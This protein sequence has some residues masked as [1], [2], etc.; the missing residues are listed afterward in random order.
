[1]RPSPDRGPGGADARGDR[2]G[3]GRRDGELRRAE[4]AGQP[5]GAPPAR[6]WA[7]GPRCWSGSAPGGRRDW[8]SALLAV[9]KAGGAYVPLD[10]AFPAGPAGF[11]LEDA[12]VAGPPHRAGPAR[13]ACR[14]ADPRSL[15]LDSR[16]GR[17]R[18]RR[19]EANLAGGVVPRAPGLR[20]LHLGL[21]RPA[22]GGAGHAR[23]RWPTSS[24]SMRELLGI[25]GR[26]RAAG[27]HD[28]LVRHRRAGDLPA[29]DRR[30]P[31]S[32]WS[33]A[34][35]RPTGPRAGR[36]ARAIRAITFLQ[37]TPATWR[38][39]LEAGWAGE[40]GAD[41]ALRRRG[42]AARPGRPA[43]RQGRGALE[44]VRADR[45]DHLVVG[46][47]RV[48][49]GDGPIPIGRPIANTQLY[50]LDGSVAPVPVGVTRRA[51]HRRPR[52]GPRLPRPAG[53]DGRAVRP[54]PVRRG[55]P[56]AGSTAPATSPAGGPTAR[57]NA[58]AG[59][60]IRSRSA[61]SASSWARS[62]PCS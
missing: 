60:T 43:A 44:P 34:R 53:P 12:G 37:A 1:M 21:D 55:H 32:S 18:R 47:A 22:Q 15:C 25:D 50:V 2:R 51:L 24:S 23:G 5:A 40:P 52:P 9:L 33:P 8:W 54:R 45:D 4:R 26:G 3:Y 56:A 6:R 57:S 14:P 59:S 62:R 39:L 58:S 10:P 29:A 61:A 46:L 36:A 28:A 19:A 31:A 11:M 35:W 38:L 13:A 30:R 7:S 17:A 42:A 16:P 27:R 49:P 48:E 20:D 41:D